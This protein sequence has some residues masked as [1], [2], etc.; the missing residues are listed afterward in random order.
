MN[1]ELKKIIDNSKRI[2]FSGGAGASTESN[3]PDFRSETG[4][5]N[6]QREYGYSPEQM[7]SHS[8]FVQKTE[9]FYDYYKNNLIYRDA[10]P[11]RAH[12]ALAA[13]EREGKLSA[14]VTQNIDGLH[15]KAGSKKVYELHG[16]VHRNYCTSCGAFYDL[17]FILSSDG[18]PHCPKC[19]G[20]IKP[21]VV[22]YEESLDEETIE[23][24][25]DAISK[26]DTMIVGGTSLAVYPAAGLL[27][28]FR[29]SRIVVIN[30]SPTHFDRNADLLLAAPIGEV[31]GDTFSDIL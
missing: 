23:R 12:L 1:E 22:L 5:Y 27:S 19:G 6:A 29:G 16:S 3:I 8:F 15:Q 7:L 30:K 24:S 21:D 18:V 13:L 9:V 4:L 10:M 14:V 17:S 25:V 26:A 31:L 11:N 28:Y 20:L 2:V